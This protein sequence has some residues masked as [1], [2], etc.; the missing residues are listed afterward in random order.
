MAL[1]LSH[2][3]AYGLMTVMPVTGIAMGYYGGK[4]LPFFFTTIPGAQG[5]D[6]NG[7]AR[8]PPKPVAV[9]ARLY[10][11]RAGRPPAGC[12]WAV[13]PACGV[14][15]AVTRGR[16]SLPASLALDYLTSHAAPC[17][18]GTLCRLPAGSGKCTRS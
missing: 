5:E 2:A 15:A 10:K 4:G 13:P 3:A 16:A 18:R 1:Q 7:K 8:R 17:D 9:R 14:K 11:G 12:A 6:K